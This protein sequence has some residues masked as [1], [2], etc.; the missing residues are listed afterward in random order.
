MTFRK[1]KMAVL[2]ILIIVFGCTDANKSQSKGSSKAND[3]KVQILA[4]LNNETRAAFERDFDQW[5]AYWVHR[6]SISKTYINYPDSTFS[7]SVGWSEISSF[8]KDF[9]E[10][11][12][13][14][15]P[16]PEL[17]KE[18]DVRLYGSG[19]WVTYEQQD[20]LRGLKRE[21]RLMEKSGGTW[22]IASMHTTIYGDQKTN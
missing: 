10:E 15:E 20:S 12:P 9:M 17:L 6:P 3:E 16:V 22:K 11:Y 18:I 14:P 2:S 7:E 4:T 19:A 8:V 5:Q 1:Q 21:V 13:E